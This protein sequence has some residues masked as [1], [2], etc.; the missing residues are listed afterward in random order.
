MYYLF[1]WNKMQVSV[2]LVKERMKCYQEKKN[3]REK[4]RFLK[5][6]LVKTREDYSL[7]ETKK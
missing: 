6:C 2:K 3:E 1:F 7:D 4:K 5:K